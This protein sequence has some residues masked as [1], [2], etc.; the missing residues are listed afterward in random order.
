MTR[1]FKAELL[2]DAAAE[3]GEGPAWDAARG[4]LMWV[5][6]MGRMVHTIGEDGIPQRQYP[7]ESDV[8]AALPAE[9]GNG[10]LAALALRDGFAILDEN[11]VRTIC[12]VDADRPQLRFNDA[13]CDPRG[14]AFGGTMR[15]DE[16]P[17]DAALY[18]LDSG[19][20]ATE[21]LSE[22]GLSNGLDWT[23]DGSRMYYIDSLARRVDEFRY[24]VETGS[25]SDRR[26]VV[27][28]PAS[29]GLP[30]GM[31]VDHDGYLWVA[32]FGGSAIHRYAP[33]GRL[34]AVVNLP[35]RNIT[36]C[37]FGGVDGDLLFIT[38]ARFALADDVLADEPHAGALFVCRPGVTGPPATPWRPILE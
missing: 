34:D 27:E 3:L 18:R 20:T 26:T 1:T 21:V 35:T 33:D 19:P 2:F 7:T 13:K 17:A 16:G 23:A 37:G 30:D 32:L 15:Y 5:D 25:I 22:V 36:S 6:I 28:I 31:C 4:H 8:G 14:R 11:G 24:D 29:V 9:P 12:P 10:V 38:S